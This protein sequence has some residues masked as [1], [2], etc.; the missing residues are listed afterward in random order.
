[1]EAS[2]HRFVR[3]LRLRGVRISVSEALDAMRCA[4]QP[5]ILADREILREA[6]RVALIKD[7]RD[8][9]TFT[10]VFDAFFSLIKVGEQ[11]HGHGH[12]HGHGDLSDEGALEN[13]TL[14]EEPSE[15]PQQGHSHGKPVDIRDYFD[16][17]DLA[18]QYN[19]HQEANKIDLAAMTEEIVFSKDNLAGP[20]SEGDRVQIET[21]R[22]SGAGLPGEVST[23]TGTKVDADLSV[24]QQEALLG[25]LTAAE[26]EVAKETGTE[27]DAAALRRRLAGVLANLPEAIKKHLERL[28]ELEQRI[29][30]NGDGDKR[31]AE[32]DRA[33]EAE[34]MQLEDSLR[35]LAKTLHG[36]LTHRRRV[37]PQG[38]VDS[39]RTMRRNMRYDGVPFNPVTVRRAED[40]P[41]LVVLADVSLSVRATARFTLHLVHGLQDLFGQVRSFGFVSDLVEIT[42]LFADHPVEKAL[43][44]VFGGD[45]LDVDAN[46]HYGLAF[47]QFLE[48]H[49]SAVTRRS[50]VLVLGDGR[51]NGNDPNMEAFIEITRRARET[52]WLTPEPRYSWGLGR[53][54]LPGYAEYCDRVRVVRDLTGL[55]ATSYEM[56][57][58]LIGR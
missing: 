46:S 52:I 5:G 14:S 42:D 32:V 47:G 1:M 40:K 30:E 51:G 20:Q 39:G 2:I 50:T 45:L 22:L 31:V 21:D 24:A 4:G 27:D 13:F 25:W 58:E 3:L 16:P 12:G 36:A 10:E 11:A 53:C 43:G 6:L 28:L 9:A 7:R 29:V 44:L 41:R 15:T 38:R 8:D 57:G 37:S 17:E 55:E 33:A 35:R 34:R 48:E 26:D 19:L 49:G 54:D 56:A 18:Q 23:A